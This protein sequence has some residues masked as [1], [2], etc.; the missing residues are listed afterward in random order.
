MKRIEEID[1]HI[2]RIIVEM[3]QLSNKINSSHPITTQ[4]ESQLHRSDERSKG[5]VNLLKYS[6][7]ACFYVDNDLFVFKVKKKYFVFSQLDL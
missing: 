5:L 2:D 4:N 3:H 7:K 6:F 1:D